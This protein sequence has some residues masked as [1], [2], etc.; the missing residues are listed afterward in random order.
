MRLDLE[1]GVRAHAGDRKPANV[2][3]T[4]LQPEKLVVR[5]EPVRKAAAR[6]HVGPA[7]TS[8]DGDK[9]VCSSLLDTTG[10]AIVV[11]N[12]GSLSQERTA[13]WESR[14]R[15]SHFKTVTGPMVPLSL[16]PG[17]HQSGWVKVVASQ[18]CHNARTGGNTY[19]REVRW[20]L[21][22]VAGSGMLHR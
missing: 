1:C 14:R 13:T 5:E 7:G 20:Q 16:R 18:N 10:A 6:Q 19:T 11:R 3:V 9:I 8:N 2:P 15:A 4:A 22:T 21:I 12:T 17:R